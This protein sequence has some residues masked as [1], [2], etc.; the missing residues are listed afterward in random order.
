MIE[1]T[2][3]HQPGC[4]VIDPRSLQRD[5]HGRLAALRALHPLVQ[6][7]EGQFLVLRADDVLPLLSDPRVRQV[8]GQEYIALNRVPEG[9]TARLQAEF[10][11]FSSGE[12]H[13]RKRGL[14]AR[15]FA[16]REIEARRPAVRTAARRI[17][18][19]LPRD[20]SLDFTTAMAS[21]VPA[22]AIA[23]ILGLPESDAPHLGALVS[24]VARAISPLYPRERHTQ[25][26]EA[27]EA[28][29]FYVERQ[30][31]ARLIQPKDDVLSLL[32]NAWRAEPDISA[33]S[34]IFQIIGVLI[35]GID[36]TRTAL[37]RGTAILLERP[38][39]WADLRADPALIPGAVAETLR[40]DPP[41]GSVTRIA[42]EPFEIGGHLVPEGSALRLSLLSALRDPALHHA[43]DVFDMRRRDNPRLHP[44]FGHGPHHCLGERLARIELEESLA[45][46][47]EEAPFAELLLSP[48]LEGF[49]G[50]RRA[51][52]MRVRLS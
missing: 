39:D 6:I 46:L 32:V 8:S 16:Y 2:T 9:M 40:F 29:Y 11:L 25:I 35:A 7:G 44:V 18:S 22:E 33:A 43:P 23:A 37:A 52:P 49:G 26:E 12:E 21:R 41:V 47:L 19:E 3:L 50:L 51:T 20:E 48:R 10:F 13:R 38:Q 34:L 24:E 5:T 14:F 31:Q 28:L 1:D 36:T 17:L 15:A 27:T 4:P 30:L 42:A 45:A